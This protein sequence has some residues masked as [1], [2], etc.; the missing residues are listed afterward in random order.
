MVGADLPWSRSGIMFRIGHLSDLHLLEDAH[1]ERGALG[2]FRL[3]FLSF[4]RPLDAAERR[5]RFRK[6]LAAAA[7]ARLDHLVITGDLTEDGTRPQFEVAAALLHESGIPPERVTLL[8]GNHDAYH[9]QNGWER[10]LEGPLAPWARTSLTGRALDLNDDVLLLPLS[11]RI[12]QHYVRSAGAV[13]ASELEAAF[14]L[15]GD[16]ASR[17]RTLVIA[18]HHPATRHLLPVVTWWDGLLNHRRTTSLVQRHA[19]VHVMHGHTH[20]RSDRVLAQG[21]GAQVFCAQA[22]VDGEQ[23][24]RVYEV[25]DGM[26]SPV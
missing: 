8:P 9:E 13:H 3:K 14:R 5:G 7:A 21:R 11:T 17:G 1:H 22:V 23:P 15:A 25:R 19:H 20:K 12:K 26:L 6:A 16:D 24:L 4:G 2:R 18:Q 10:A